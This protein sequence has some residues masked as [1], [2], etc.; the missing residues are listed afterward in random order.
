MIDDA[1]QQ[2][3]TFENLTKLMQELI[4]GESGGLSQFE[5]DQIVDALMRARGRMSREVA[6]YRD[7]L[8]ELKPAL[9][10]SPH[11][12]VIPDRRVIAVFDQVFQA[13]E[14]WNRR[15]DRNLAEL[16]RIVE[17]APGPR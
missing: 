7:A 12:A 13:V 3:A 17:S 10:L 2:V 16:P 4:Q 6:G 11:A 5:L 8:D 14:A 9:G 1:R 15:S